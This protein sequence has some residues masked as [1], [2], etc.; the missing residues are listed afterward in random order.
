[1]ARG[2]KLGDNVDRGATGDVSV[3]DYIKRITLKRQDPGRRVAVGS[4]DF[5]P[6]RDTC[7]P[8]NCTH[9]ESSPN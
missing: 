9:C 5:C 3:S 4:W 2:P 8:E 1:M 6:V 7:D